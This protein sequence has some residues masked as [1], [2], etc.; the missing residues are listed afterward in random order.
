MR[1]ISGTIQSTPVQ[2]LPTLSHIPPPH[3]RRLLALKNEA[4]K[5]T[6]NPNLPVHQEFMAPP[7]HRLKSRH[8]PYQTAI[9]LLEKPFDI[10]T[11]W[12]GEWKLNP[13]KATASHYDPTQKPFGFSAPRREWCQLKRLRTGHGLCG[14]YMF[15]CGW[16][17]SPMCDCGEPVQ[18]MHHIIYDCPKRKY[19]GDTL[20]LLLPDENAARWV[21]EL[22]VKL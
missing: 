9:D 1:C 8:P 13:P 18:S 20:D 4:K 6:G 21:K 22:D 7:R 19:P 11:R 10:K 16:R 15:K 12:K 5:I 3:L 2:W 17:E 14:E